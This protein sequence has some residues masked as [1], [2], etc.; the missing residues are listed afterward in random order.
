MLFNEGTDDFF[1]DFHGTREADCFTCQPLDAG[2]EGQVVTFNTLREDRYCL[3][4]ENGFPDKELMICVICRGIKPK[5]RQGQESMVYL[6]VTLS[7]RP[8]PIS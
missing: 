2:A 4:S 8:M 3:R 7:F 6:L 1:V 5:N